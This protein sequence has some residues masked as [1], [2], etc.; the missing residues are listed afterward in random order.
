MSKNRTT[1]LSARARLTCSHEEIPVKM[2]SSADR[3]SRS[4]VD[5]TFTIVI[6]ELKVLTR[7]RERLRDRRVTSVGS[8]T[9]RVSADRDA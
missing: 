4:R 2:T 6:G 7:Y 5:A 1:D 3:F 8:S 9:R